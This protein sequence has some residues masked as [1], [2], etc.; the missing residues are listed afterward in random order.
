MATTTLAA[1]LNT[2]MSELRPAPME[3]ILVIED[4]AALRKILQRLFSSEGYEVD[5]VPDG[6]PGLEML[7]QRAPD[8][9][10][11]D[12]LRP[13]LRAVTFARKLQV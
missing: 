6:R 12:L 3:R 8:A 5:I 13:D 1:T 10:I 9:V 2:P 11:L 4:D 7:R